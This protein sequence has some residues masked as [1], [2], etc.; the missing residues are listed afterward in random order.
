[1]VLNEMWL[2]AL[3]VDT[4]TNLDGFQMRKADRVAESGNRKGGGLAVF[5]QDR[6]CSSGQIIV[7]EQVCSKDIKPFSG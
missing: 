5:V 1:M 3:T 2:I 4:N 7:K 6:W